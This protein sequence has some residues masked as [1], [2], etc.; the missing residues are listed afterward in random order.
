MNSA[1]RMECARKMPRG[2]AHIDAVVASPGAAEKAEAAVKVAEERAKTKAAEDK[3]GRTKM[4]LEAEKA[5]AVI[6]KH[7][8]VVQENECAVCFAEFAELELR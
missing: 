5:R 8:R 6:K 1:S 3:L 7:D 2:T 4:A